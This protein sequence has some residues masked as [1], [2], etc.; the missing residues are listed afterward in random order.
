VGIFA[1]PHPRKEKKQKRNNASLI[2][3]A[4]MM[5]GKKH[6]IKTFKIVLRGI[7]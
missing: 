7:N 4:P 6:K 5:A 1:A 3:M 2:K